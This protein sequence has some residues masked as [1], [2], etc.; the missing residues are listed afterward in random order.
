MRLIFAGTPE[1]AAIALQELATK[2]EIALVITRHDAPVG[3]KR[4]LTPSPVAEV[5]D[6]LGIETMKTNQLSE[7]E[8][9]RIKG[10]N[11]DLGVVVAFGALL[12][13][14]ALDALEWWNL[15]FSLLPK[16][17][18]AT[19]LQHSIIHGEGQ[20]LTVFRLDEGMDT[21]DVVGALPM[22]FGPEQTSAELMPLLA[23]DGAKL[24]LELLKKRPAATAQLGEATF[25]PKFSR[26]DAKL[27]FEESAEVNARL[28]MAL[29]P[30]PVAWTEAGD[31]SIRILRAKAVGSID[32]SSLEEKES[33]IGSVELSGGKVLVTCGGGTRLQL[34]MVQPAGKK[35]MSALDWFRG[36]QTGIVLG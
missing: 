19:P 24:I 18:G 7:E 3:R 20:G 9:A 23:N 8:I 25:A 15:H 2:H 35:A 30:E 6:R 36:L 29:N 17:R 5:A 11:A 27:S 10:E 16:W 13:R 12:P 14:E 22:D 34:E 4:V 21:G 1:V 28:I 33:A 26:A 32:W 31:E